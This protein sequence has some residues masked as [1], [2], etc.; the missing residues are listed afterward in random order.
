[1]NRVRSIVDRLLEDDAPVDPQQPKQAAPDE[2]EDIRKLFLRLNRPPKTNKTEPFH[3]N[4]SA[5][6]GLRRY[7]YF[8]EQLGNRSKRKLANNTYLERKPDGSISIR[9]HKTD[10][11]NY[12]PDG[13]GTFSTGGWPTMSTRRRMSDYISGDWSIYSESF[14]KHGEETPEL[15]WDMPVRHGYYGIQGGDRPIMSGIGKPFWYNRATNAGTFD[16]GWRIPF[17]DGDQIRP[18]GTLLHQAKPKE[19]GLRNAEYGWP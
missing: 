15:W 1:M 5:G 13:T 10:I 12:K 7:R 2:D 11:V 9:F 6:I 19:R 18:D 16:S 17:T 8:N 3:A 4:G 14:K